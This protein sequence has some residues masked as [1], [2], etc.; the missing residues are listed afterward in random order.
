M[1]FV[2]LPLAS[3]ANIICNAVFN[4][5]SIFLQIKGVITVFIVHILR[6]ALGRNCRE[7]TM[8]MVFFR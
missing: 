2:E 6:L 1:N 4:S 5:R 7:F 3:S 8:V